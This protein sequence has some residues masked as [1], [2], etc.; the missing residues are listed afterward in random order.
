MSVVIELFACIK[1][2]VTHSNATKVLTSHARTLTHIH[3]RIVSAYMHLFIYFIHLLK[4][5]K[6]TA[7]DPKTTDLSYWR[8]SN[9]S[10]CMLF[11]I[12]TLSVLFLCIRMRAPAFV[13]VCVCAF[14]GFYC[15][16]LCIVNWMPCNT[17]P[18]SFCHIQ[19]LQRHSSA[20]WHQLCYVVLCHAML[21]YVA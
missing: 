19:Y 12:S 1:S 11:C 16:L 6:H 7:R 8:C 13:F 17:F 21:C 10:L 14:L 3:R 5:S 20:I 4:V 9:I 2:P 15:N 18:F